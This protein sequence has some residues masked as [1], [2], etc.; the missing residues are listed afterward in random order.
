MAPQAAQRTASVRTPAPLTR[1][2]PC[3]QR[4]PGDDATGPAPYLLDARAPK[5]RVNARTGRP[6]HRPTGA[7]AW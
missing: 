2:R 5:A 7:Q 4:A 1:I 3:A 6:E